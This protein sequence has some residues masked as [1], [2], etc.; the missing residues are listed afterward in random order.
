M[1][2][3]MK[4]M[5]AGLMVGVCVGVTLTADKRRSKKMINRAVRNMNDMADRMAEALGI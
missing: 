3:F 2:S 5:G 1:C 4:G